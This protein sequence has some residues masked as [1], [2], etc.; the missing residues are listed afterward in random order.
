M[1]LIDLG[2]KFN[3]TG[4]KTWHGLVPFVSGSAGLA[5]SSGGPVDSSGYNF[6]RKLTV[7]PGVGLRWYPGGR[8]AITL[9]GRAVLWRLHYP[10]DFKRISSPDGIPVLAGN[11]PENEWTTH[12]SFRV[13][14]GWTF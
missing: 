3:L 9:E 13:G 14:V 5:I 12:P 8:M 2:L 4:L 10:V 1:L 11:E 6:R 7:A